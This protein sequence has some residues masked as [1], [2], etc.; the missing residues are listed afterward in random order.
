M[1]LSTLFNFSSLGDKITPDIKAIIIFALIAL[2]A[3]IFKRIKKRTPSP[4][5]LILISAGLGILFY[6]F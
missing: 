3:L 4:V 6:S 1:L 2:T 5:V